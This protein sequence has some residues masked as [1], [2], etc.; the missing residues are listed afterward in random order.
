M[1]SVAIDLA[2]EKTSSQ[3]SAT[4]DDNLVHSSLRLAFAIYYFLAF[5]GQE[6]TTG[7]SIMCTI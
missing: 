6:T 5:C 3:G 1:I 7:S 4:D 2:G